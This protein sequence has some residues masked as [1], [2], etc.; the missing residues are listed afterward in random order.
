[1]CPYSIIS[2]SVNGYVSLMGLRVDEVYHFP[3]RHDGVINSESCPP[4]HVEVSLLPSTKR[5]PFHRTIE[6]DDSE[7]EIREQ[8]A[9]MARQRQWRQLLPQLQDSTQPMTY[10]A[11]DRSRWVQDNI[12]HQQLLQSTTG[13]RR[14][15]DCT[16][17]HINS[18]RKLRELRGQMAHKA[19]RRHWRQWSPVKHHS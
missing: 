3:T 4:Y 18:H 17:E 16:S 9:H 11:Y 6:P 19:H 5:W 14:S 10:I 13:H 2:F 8:W 7:V 12:N 15:R 1:M